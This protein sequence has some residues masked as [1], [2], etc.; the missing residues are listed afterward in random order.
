MYDAEVLKRWGIHTSQLPAGSDVLFA[1]PSLW[2]A[3]RW[4][5]VGLAVLIGL[6][7]LLILLLMKN[8]DRLRTTRAELL[9]NEENIRL[10]ARAARLG[11]WTLD[12]DH[13]FLWITDEGRALFGWSKSESLGFNR[14]LETLPPQDREPAKRAMR[15]ALEGGDEFEAEH[16]IVLG[17]GNERW[18]TTRGRAQANGHGKPV[19]ISGVSMD[20]TSRKQAIHEAQELRRELSHTG[21]LSLLSQFTTSL[22]HEL[23]QPL[24]AIQ[25]NADA[26]ELFL[27][28]SPP[29][30]DE[31]RSIVHDV[32]KDCERAGMVIDRLRAMLRRRG[33]EVQSLAWNDLAY[34][35]VG[36]VRAESQARGITLEVEAPLGLPHLKGDRVQI[37]QVLINLVANAMDAIDTQPQGERRVTVSARANG[38]GTVECFV[39]D[40]G[41]GIA[42]ECMSGMFDPFVTTKANGMGMGLPIC[43]TLIE[44]MGGRLWAEN[45][46]GKGTTFRFTLPV[47]NS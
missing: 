26:A 21:R 45:N 8:R 32:R 42:P 15:R 41:P 43:Q 39:R 30:L 46:S 11:F 13:D 44:T 2:Q 38:N 7:A 22:A 29:D 40:T 31:I 25:R 33:I 1:R 12:I 36:L 37:Q 4:R 28:A 10:A 14:F 3:Y 6:E 19:L 24:G 23:G 18:I 5:L 9:K 27:K 35:A 20:V 34:E 47:S 16:R 17:D